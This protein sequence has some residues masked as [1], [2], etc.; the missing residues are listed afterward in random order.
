MSAAIEIPLRDTDEVR[1][2]LK[3]SRFKADVRKKDEHI[4]IFNFYKIFVKIRDIKMFKHIINDNLQ[5][6]KWF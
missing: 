3:F 1:D 4:L 2:L 5:V 6:S